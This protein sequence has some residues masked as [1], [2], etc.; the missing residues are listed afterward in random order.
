MLTGALRWYS[1][2]KRQ[3]ELF[4]QE[5]FLEVGKVAEILFLQYR[6]IFGKAV[7]KY[8]DTAVRNKPMDNC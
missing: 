4:L 6:N 8:S 3:S 2:K 1:I 7:V 5:V